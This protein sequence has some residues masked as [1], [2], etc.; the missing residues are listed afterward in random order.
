MP[1]IPRHYQMPKQ[2]K[3][4]PVGM[5]GFEI[6]FKTVLCCSCSSGIL[7]LSLFVVLAVDVHKI[8]CM[9]IFFNNI[10]N[11]FSEHQF[12]MELQT[13]ILIR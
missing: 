13:T 4:I 6:D 8:N 9:E 11:K 3:V 5:K 7:R 2:G 10:F 1:P 12:I